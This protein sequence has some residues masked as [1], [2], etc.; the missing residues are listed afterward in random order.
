MVRH[1]RRN[2][3]FHTRS[4][5]SAHTAFVK[6][7][8]PLGTTEEDLYDCLNG[9]CPGVRAGAGDIALLRRLLP[10]TFGCQSPPMQSVVRVIAVQ[11]SSALD[12]VHQKRVNAERLLQRYEVE[13]ELR[14]GRQPVAS[15]P[16]PRRHSPLLFPLGPVQRATEAAGDYPDYTS[17]EIELAAN[18]DAAAV[19]AGAAQEAGIDVHD[20]LPPPP[21]GVPD[22]AG[23]VEVSLKSPNKDSLQQSRSEARKGSQGEGSSAAPSRSAAS[24]EELPTDDRGDFV[25]THVPVTAPTEPP[26][27][28]PYPAVAAYPVGPLAPVAPAPRHAG[29]WTGSPFEGSD[30]LEEW[31]EERDEGPEGM[32]QE[33]VGQH[34]RKLPWCAKHCPGN[35]LLCEPSRCLNPK[36]LLRP[37][38]SEPD[39]TGLVEQQ[40]RK[41]EELKRQERELLVAFRC[42]EVRP[43][44]PNCTLSLPLPLTLTL[45]R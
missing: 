44:W 16:G 30:R 26:G 10:L 43:R 13:K 24:G 14:E 1:I 5:E 7:G 36:R 22:P 42:R 4:V 19:A 12:A 34:R 18:M 9:V 45:Q 29:V 15:P 20:V 8:I 2:R 32:T 6:S 40:R 39:M 27:A 37:F 31:P 28:G 23:L 41:V 33:N 25:P 35:A 38:G 11:N 21:A 3:A 17:E